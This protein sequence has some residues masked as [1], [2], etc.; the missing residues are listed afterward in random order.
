MATLVS[1]NSSP[2]PSPKSQKNFFRDEI[3]F[4]RNQEKQNR[5]S[6]EFQVFPATENKCALGPSK[7][8]CWFPFSTISWCCLFAVQTKFLERQNEIKVVQLQLGTDTVG[9]LRQCGSWSDSEMGSPDIWA[10]AEVSGNCFSR[11][12]GEEINLIR[13]DNGRKFHFYV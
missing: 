6:I 11:T 9:S 10:L 13:K 2:P 12:P 1:I 3:Y 5:P 4:N 7:P 8:I